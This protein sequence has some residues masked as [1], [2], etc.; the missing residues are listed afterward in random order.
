MPSVRAVRR[1]LGWRRQSGRLEGGSPSLLAPPAQTREYLESVFRV[2]PHPEEFVKY[3]LHSITGLEMRQINDWFHN[4]RGPLALP[5]PILL[6]PAFSF[7]THQRPPTPPP[8][9]PPPTPAYL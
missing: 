4:R 2:N 5:A 3:R 9:P 6:T 7:F 8:S 1:N